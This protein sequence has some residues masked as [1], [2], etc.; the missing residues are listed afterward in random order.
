MKRYSLRRLGTSVLAIG[1]LIFSGMLSADARQGGSHPTGNI[2]QIAQAAGSF[3][4]LIA[5]LQATD[6]SS[7]LADESQHFTVF[8]PT[9]EAFALLGKDTIDALIADPETLSNILLYH[10]IPGQVVDAATAI[11]LSGSKVEAANGDELAIQ[12]KGQRLFINSST[13]IATDVR[14]TNG[15]IH[16]IDSVL[17][18]PAA[19]PEPTLNIVETAS[20]AENLGTLVSLLVATGLDAVLADAS[21][22]FTVFA[23]TDEA[24]AKLDAATLEAL[25][26][27]PDRLKDLLLYH[28]LAGQAVD[29]ATAIS[30][31]GNSVETANGQN[32]AISLRS[33]ELFINDSKVVAT[34]VRATNG[35]VHL[36]DT[37]LM[38]PSGS[39]D[40]LPTLADIVQGNRDFG[41][42]NIALKVSG[43]SS[44]LAD[45]NAT[46]TVFA[47]NNRAFFKLGTSNLFRLFRD[48]E[49]LKTVLLYHVIPD[50]KVDAATAFTLD[51]AAV[52]TANGQDV[53][54]RVSG[55]NL[56]INRSQVIAT[57]IEASN[58]IAH[59]IDS[60]LIPRLH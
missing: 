16:V 54:V 56:F 42:L 41:I 48:R 21:T 55:D 53:T 60:V 58:G 20:S 23:P 26:S 51:T 44:V 9:D 47:P 57:D 52:P 28:V 24:F 1:A 11:S 15:I 37:V 13:V 40:D 8:A 27:D 30:L 33:D 2:V 3:N 49:L 18:P 35:I 32:V 7:V 31:A 6:L 59:V 12:A 25:Q 38:P 22:Q 45:E 43:L 10:V 34:D 50:S 46:F 39:P 4:T 17:M 36:I 29:A 14:A 19:M 5:A